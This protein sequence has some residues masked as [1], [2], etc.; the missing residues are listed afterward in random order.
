MALSLS[1]T[2]FEQNFKDDF[3][4]SDGYYRI[5]FNSGRTLQARELTQMQTIIQKQIER[6]GSHVF[7]EGGIVK[8]AEQILNNA[9]EF[10]KLDPTSNA[11]ATEGIVGTT[12]TGATS[13]VTARA[14]EGVQATTSDPATIYFAYTNA[15]ASQAGLN[16]VRFLPGEVITN[17]TAVLTV[18]ITNTSDNPAVGRGT[19]LSIGEAIYYVQGYFVFVEAQSV[20]VS[21]YT[22]TVNDTVGF[23]INEQ[24]IDVDDDEGLYDNQGS[25]PNI[26]APGADRYQIKLA[27]AVEST[28]DSA[29]NFIPVVTL[30]NGVIY[31]ATDENNSYNI[32]RDVIATRIKENSGNYLVKPFHL[33]ISKD[34]D[35]TQ[36]QLNVG[37]GIAVIEGYRSAIHAPTKIRIPKPA[38]TSEIQNE[39]TAAGYGNYVLVDAGD[40]SAQQNKGLPDVS[41][42]AKQTL[43]SAA[44]FGGSTMGTCRV[45]A[46]SEDTGNLYRFYL[47]DIQMD[48]G[49]S[50]RNVV[51]IGVDAADYFNLFRPNGKAVLNEPA[52]NHALFTLPHLRPRSLDD[53]S[54]ITQ[55]RF[56]VTSDGGGAASLSLSATGETFANVNDWVIANEDS[57]IFI[58]TVGGLGAA[59][60]N[61]AANLTGLPA[62]STVEVLAF[63]NKANGVVR[64]KTLVETT[65]T[66]SVVGGEINLGKADVFEVT[67]IRTKDSNGADITNKFEFD[68]GQRDNFY[69]RGRLV[70][71]SG[72]S[73]PTDKVFVR[74]K[75]F[76]HGVSGDFF[77]INSYTGQVDY[78]KIPSHRTANGNLIS[79]RNVL[80][81]RPVQDS[82]GEFVN[83]GTG[84][85]VNEFPEVNSTTQADITYYLHRATTLTLNEEGILKLVYGTDDFSPVPPQLP[86]SVMPLYNIYFGGNTLNDSDTIVERI[87]H[88]RY[89]MK[90]IGKLEERIDNVEE[91]VALNL[92]E[93]D[94]KNI[95]VLDSAGLDRTKSG[96]FVDNFST[97]IFCDFTGD[98][99]RASIDPQRNTLNPAYTEDN[100]RLIYDS[101][102]STNTIK[103]GDNVY[104]AHDDELY[105]S[106]EK[107]SQAVKINPFSAVIYHGDIDLSPSSDEWRDVIVNSKKMINGGTKLNTDQSTL[108]N[109]WQWNWGGTPVNDLKVGSTT[110]S[111][112]ETQTSTHTYKNIQKVTS[113]ETVLEVVG[114]RILNIALIPFMRSQKIFFRAQGMRPSSSM[115]A[116][117]DGVSVADFVREETFNR[118]SDGDTDHGNT[119]NN[120]TAHPEGATALTSDVN[121]AIEGSFFIPNTSNLKFRTGTL[122]FKLLDVSKNAEADAGSIARALYSAA[123]TIDTVDQDIK[124]TRVLHVETVQVAE[125]RKATVSVQSHDGPDGQEIT[126]TSYY[127]DAAGSNSW[128]V[129][130]IGTEAESRAAHAHSI[131]ESQYDQKRAAKD[132]DDGKSPGTVLCSLLYRRGYL[133]QSIWEQDAA[134]GKLVDK[135]V[136]SGYHAWAIPMVEW[137][138]KDSLLAK[139]WFNASVLPL[140]KCWAQHIAHRMKPE[141]HKDN[142]IGRLVAMIGIPICKLIGSTINKN[143]VMEPKQ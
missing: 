70:L 56:Q 4:D 62:S 96:F 138:E 110:N 124:S 139:L 107:A 59:A 135:E 132:P 43:K 12:F 125:Q 126:G 34:S 75:H 58:G 76:N 72:F 17:G 94:T 3:A 39:V 50:F 45:R 131:I 36:L 93:M 25:T 51:S 140:T 114:E 71:K 81:F 78:D 128:S 89:T 129:P 10:V 88:K 55:R 40:M 116:Y 28:A 105:V 30:K 130:N 9:Y 21:K 29:L 136:L 87:E 142:K 22:D 61:I 42:L 103:K 102:S 123:G 141:T 31:R 109:N 121:G 5:L 118:Y 67:R 46:V 104:I 77:A 91:H 120:I 41:T 79:L 48:A 53:I 63:V 117:F 35:N 92:L 100:I 8:P 44:N 69:A 47:F 111:A 54:L 19:R 66:K 134:F 57:S 99:Y 2:I 101:A 122:E 27:L 112:V 52:K 60:G 37:D 82:D 86:N 80:D 14:L 74:Y 115:F 65:I 7:K 24:V 119:Q 1:K 108:W 95:K 38:S 106:N 84:A 26:S 97:Q 20:I 133:P 73:A 68:N 11:L 49:Q 15:P 83:T 98:Q 113:E 16:T 85:R 33:D 32:T 137:I 18:Q 23:T 127:Q 90:D 64:P 13:G 6:F 143:I